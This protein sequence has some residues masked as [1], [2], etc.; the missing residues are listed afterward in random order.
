M[1]PALELVQF[2]VDAHELGPHE[3]AILCKLILETDYECMADLMDFVLSRDPE[4]KPEATVVA[5][6]LR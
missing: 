4:V 3:F 2:L 6:W 5:P 1:N